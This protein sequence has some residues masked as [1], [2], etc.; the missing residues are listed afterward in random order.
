MSRF[1]RAKKVHGQTVEGRR[2]V[3]ES[4]RA[5][6]DI[7][8]LVM[9]QDADL[10]AQLQEIVMLASE[11]GIPVEAVS[12]KELDAQSQTKKNQGVIAVVPDPRYHEPE[13]LLLGAETGDLPPLLVMLDGIQDP[14]NLGAIARTADAVGAHGMIIPE[15]RA[16]GITPGA[17]RASAGALE[18][19]KVS[20]VTN[21]NRTLERLKGMGMMVIGLDAEGDVE[22]TEAN[23]SG[24][25]VIVIGSEGN[26]L[27]RLVR[28]NC[29][30]I[31]SIP[32][33]GQL[34][35]LNASVSAGLVLYEAFR[36][37]RS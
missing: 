10:G 1:S 15:R 12:R 16:V 18:H 9:V 36:Q 25:V 23:F 26:G 27:S 3:L 29:D 32:M 34:S 20:K 22:Y 31:A 17:V 14:H 13:D 37:R 5:E 24:P 35:S 6:R 8:K 11:A 2:A 30:Q 19:V 21:L 4:L 33:A 7:E 28:E